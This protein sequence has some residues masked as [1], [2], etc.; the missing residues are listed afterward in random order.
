MATTTDPAAGALYAPIDP[1][2]SGFL[3]VSSVH[4]VYYEQCG[5]KNGL[6]VVFLH[7]GPGGGVGPDDRRYFD[8][9]VYR[10]ILFDQ[11][12]AGKSTPTASLEDNSTW[13]LVADIEALRTRLDVDRWVVFGGSWGS[14]LA[15]TYAIRHADRVA[16]L[17][18][19]GIF[20]LRKSEI[21]WFYQSGASHIF[22]D[23]WETYT[24]PIPPDEHNDFIRAY[25]RRLTGDDAE[26]RRRCGVAWSTWE[27]ATS[28]LY[29]DPELLKRAQNDTWADQFARIECHYF[30]NEGFFEKDGWILDNVEKIRHIPA[31][32][33]QGRYDVV[34]PA[35]TAW[36]LHRKWPEAEFHLI[37]DA[38]HSAKEEGIRKRLVLAADRFARELGGAAAAGHE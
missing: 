23:A 32:I 21:D 1:Y 4:S 8:P 25:H 30:V 22:P 29:T 13:A 26:V 7:G 15:L 16:A 37:A 11:R 31:V 28:K 3:Q 24:S 5:N 38:G 36:E 17:V 34:C 35:T 9:A 10:I 18:L 12:G 14:T 6:P 20:T 27:M 33:V 19:R 2:D